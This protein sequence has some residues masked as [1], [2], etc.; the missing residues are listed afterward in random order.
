MSLIIAK[1]LQHIVR[2][3][4]CDHDIREFFGPTCV[5][6]GRTGDLD[7][8]RFMCGITGILRFDGSGIDR[9]VLD[10]MTASLVHRGPDGSGLYIDRHAGLGHRRL[11]IIDLEGGSQPLSNENGTVWVTFNGEIFNYQD[12]RLELERHGHVFKTVSD[13]EILVHG[14]EQWGHA[15]PS[16]LRGMFACVVWDAR[17]D[18]LFVARDRVGIKPLYYVRQPRYFA[19][20]SEMQAFRSIADFSPTVDPQAIDLYL[21][22]QYVPA[23]HTIYRE[24]QKLPPAHWLQVSGDGTVIGPTRYWDLAFRPDRSLN[25]NQ[26]IERLDAALEETVRTHLVADVPF[27]AFLSGGVDSSMMLAY[28]S[29]ILKQPVK[30][31]CIGH[32]REDYDERQFARQAAMVC[33]AEYVEEVVEPD[34]MSLLPELVRHYGEPFGDSSAIPTYYASRLARRHVKMVLSGDGGDEGFAGYHSYPAIL[35][36]HRA[37]E[38][39]LR[40]VRHFLANRARAF[41]CW[42]RR[43]TIADSKYERSAVVSPGQRN[44]MW[45]PEFRHLISETRSSFEASFSRGPRDELLNHLQHFD[46][47]NYVAFDNLTKVDVASMSH[48]L[49]VRVPLLDHVFL[50]IAAQVPPELKLA[51]PRGLNGTPPME[52]VIGKYLLKRTAERFFPR[53]FIHREK[54]GFEVPIREW[55]AGPFQTELRGRLLADDGPLTDYFESE[56]LVDLVD[57]SGKS[58]TQAWQAWLLLVLHEWLTQSK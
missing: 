31:F 36:E 33:G 42:P 57:S 22:F 45:R 26:W 5:R 43:T 3:N 11:S 16:R 29:R 4:F 25:E 6:S 44:L 40:K 14:Y 12:L 37:P 27:G 28:M 10:S 39:N 15:L 56:S 50:E 52:K 2:Q 18:C 47:F 34:A 55:F 54:R 17:N 41:G 46:I 21:H 20:A 58:R 13:T 48:G 38:G 32:P 7:C 51:A 23:P 8:W 9:T 24:V 1:L 53:D 19:F 30:A 35:W 49:E